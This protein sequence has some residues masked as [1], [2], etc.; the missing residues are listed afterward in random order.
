MLHVNLILFLI[1]EALYFGRE[2][3]IVL[4]RNSIYELDSSGV[5]D[6]D[7]PHGLKI[8]LFALQTHILSDDYLMCDIDN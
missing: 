4:V 2:S 8:V 6:D 3:I 5:N 7:L 1:D